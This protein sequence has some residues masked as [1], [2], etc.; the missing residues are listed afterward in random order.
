[1]YCVA[2]SIVVTPLRYRL[3][4]SSCLAKVMPFLCFL[5]WQEAHKTWMSFE[6]VAGY[7]IWCKCR[8][9]VLPHSLHTVALMNLRKIYSCC[10]PLEIAYSWRLWCKKVPFSFFAPFLLVF[11]GRLYSFITC[12]IRSLVTPY[13]AP[14]SFSVLPSAWYSLLSVRLSQLCFFILTILY[15]LVGG[16]S[17]L[18]KTT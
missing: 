6:F 12:R 7:I 15:T 3:Y 8:L 13:I 4:I 9:W 5:K 18:L 16:L 1:L 11:L 14:I 10:L 17:S 2:R